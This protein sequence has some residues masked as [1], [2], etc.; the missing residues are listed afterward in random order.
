MTSSVRASLC[1]HSGQSR[2]F[3]VIA[4]SSLFSSIRIRVKGWL[5]NKSPRSLP[6]IDYFSNNNRWLGNKSPRSLPL[7]AHSLTMFQTTIVSITYRQ[8]VEQ[9]F[10]L[11]WTF[12]R[13][14]SSKI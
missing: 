8:Q 9:E 3:I 13:L 11:I 7:I 10:I 12:L 6:L 1:R 2:W 5:G 14:L 4:F